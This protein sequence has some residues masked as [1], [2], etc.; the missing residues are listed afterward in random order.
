VQRDQFVTFQSDLGNSLVA[1]SNWTAKDK[2]DNY[3]LQSPDGHAWIQVLTFSVEG[4]GSMEEFRETIIAS[5]LPKKSSGWTQSPWSPVK[6][7]DVEA[8]HRRL[9]PSP[10]G[11]H[12]WRV[13]LIQSGSLYHAIVLNAT[14]LAMEANGDFYESIV[15]TFQGIRR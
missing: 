15:L 1:P 11:E 12:E 2:G 4:S 9:V 14:Q 5:F 7:G 10:V 6:I 13:Y 8:I 3:L